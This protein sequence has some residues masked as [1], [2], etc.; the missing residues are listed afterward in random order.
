MPFTQHLQ[1]LFFI[2]NNSRLL[3]NLT[4]FVKSYRYLCLQY[5]Q[6]NKVASGR[7][8]RPPFES[9]YRNPILKRAHNRK[10]P[11][12]SLQTKTCS[13]PRV[14]H[15]TSAFNRHSFCIS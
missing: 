15:F 14:P 10:L 3:I 1:D 5:P 13:V 8:P 4:E 6:V 7:F 2:A 12:P 9:F 11:F